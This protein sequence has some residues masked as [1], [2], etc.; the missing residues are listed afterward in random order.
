[1]CISAAS[2]KT[3][4]LMDTL[5]HES[6]KIDFCFF[7]DSRAVKQTKMSCLETVQFCG[8]FLATVL[9]CPKTTN[10]LES[11]GSQA[12]RLDK[13]VGF[14]PFSGQHFGN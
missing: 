7:W 2:K 12:P 11:L 8:S 3:K 1:M 6:E 10:L 13:I 4:K 9:S 5:P 14:L